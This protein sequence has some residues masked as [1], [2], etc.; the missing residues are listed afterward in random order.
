[1][2]LKLFSIFWHARTIIKSSSDEL[3]ILE[4]VINKNQLMLLYISK[5]CACMINNFKIT[6][7]L[8]IINKKCTP[9]YIICQCCEQLINIFEPTGPVPKQSN[10]I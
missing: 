2:L 8:K 1:M 10:W 4:N 6:S 9:R 3:L 5:Y 7:E